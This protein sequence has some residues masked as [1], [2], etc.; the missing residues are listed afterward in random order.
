MRV[1]PMERTEPFC[2][3]RDLENCYSAALTRSCLDS[4]PRGS[5]A[6][7]KCD[8]PLVRVRKALKRLDVPV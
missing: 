6:V 2:L 1:G 4:Q 7:L 5:F 3:S 8:L